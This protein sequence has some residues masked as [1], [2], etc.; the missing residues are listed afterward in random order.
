MS[1]KYRHFQED[2][3]VH[4]SFVSSREEPRG[5]KLLQNW[6]SHKAVSSFGNTF[7]LPWPILIIPKPVAILPFHIMD[8]AFTGSSLSSHPPLCNTSKTKIVIKVTKSS[9]WPYLPSHTHIGYYMPSY[10]MYN[11]YYILHATCMCLK[12]ESDRCNNTT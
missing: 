11:C 7:L 10:D 1:G 2:V 3:T 12:Q 4:D 5:K 8:N 9:R 6:S